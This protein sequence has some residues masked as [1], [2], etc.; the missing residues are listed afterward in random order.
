MFK[1]RLGTGVKDGLLQTLLFGLRSNLMKSSGRL[2]SLIL[3]RLVRGRCRRLLMHLW[4]L[5][6]MIRRSLV[7]KIDLM[8]I[9]VEVRSTHCETFRNMFIIWMASFWDRRERGIRVILLLISRYVCRVAYDLRLTTA[10][11]SPHS[12]LL[13]PGE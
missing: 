11:R 6:L 4:G 5:E 2:T 7:G 1:Y 13:C 12:L 3:R 10:C 9:W 8:N